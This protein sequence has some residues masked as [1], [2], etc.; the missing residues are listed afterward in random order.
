MKTMA[1]VCL[2][3]GI[4][5]AQELSL[6]RGSS[7]SPILHVNPGE[8]V[9]E[10][11]ALRQVLGVA[12]GLLPH[13]VSGPSSLDTAVHADFR[14]KLR[15]Q[16]AI[17]AF[18]DALVKKLALQYRI[19]ESESA[20]YALRMIDGQAH[21]M[22]A[23]QAAKPHAR[24]DRSGIDAEGLD[25]RFLARQLE[26][27]LRKPV[28]DETALSGGFD[29]ELSFRDDQEDSI[30]AA[31]SRQL[32]LQLVPIRKTERRLRVESLALPE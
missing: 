16:A 9:I 12:F 32:G 24:S 26:R 14:T 27:A 21:K 23:S 18:R 11:V 8:I 5:S 30:R 28:L 4:G 22:T 29:F 20:G 1:L 15:D 3:A 19:E 10:G 7:G 13:Q 17:D 31:V 6:K 2:L 25:M